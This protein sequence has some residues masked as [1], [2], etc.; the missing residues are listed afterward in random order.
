MENQLLKSAID[1][2]NDEFITQVGQTVKADKG[3]VRHGLNVVVPALFLG[4]SQHA[5]AGEGLGTIVEQAR[6]RFAHFDLEQL[7]GLGMTSES[8]ESE[9]QVLVEPPSGGIL[10]SL[11]GGKLQTVLHSVSGYLGWGHESVQKLMAISLPAVF[12]ALTNRGQQWDTAGIAQKLKDNK[13]AFAAAIPAGLGLGEFGKL[14]DGNDFAAA[15]TVVPTAVPTSGAVTTDEIKHIEAH[16]EPLSL[17]RSSESRAAVAVPSRSSGA[18]WWKVLI[19][20]LIVALIWFFFGKGCSSGKKEG[21]TDTSINPVQMDSSGRDVQGIAGQGGR[22]TLEV[23][24]PNGVKLAAFKGG[25]ED[26]LVQFLK[27]DYKVLGEDSLKNTWFD[28][29]NLNFKTAT[30]TV[31]PESQVQLSNLSE[32]L[33]A[34]SAAKVKIGGYTDKTGNEEFNKKLSQERANAVKDFL[35]SAGLSQQIVGAEGYGSQYAKF[36]ADAPETDRITDRHVA[37]SVR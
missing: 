34:F 30:A 32:I 11:F 22:E 29:D 20:L 17:P 16:P 27:S 36:P 3:Q 5:E 26:K 14:F 13:T 23:I 18:G 8:V 10:A 9:H 2:F 35:N 12:A 19:V 1:F 15:E 7:F 25:I 24:L 6:E 31:L 4:L 37:V 21:A 33:K 28:F